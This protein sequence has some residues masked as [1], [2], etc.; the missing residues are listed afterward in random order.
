MVPLLNLRQNK[1][2]LAQHNDGENAS[3]RVENFSLI[4]KDTSTT[5]GTRN[6]LKKMINSMQPLN[7]IPPTLYTKTMLVQQTSVLHNYECRSLF[8]L[9]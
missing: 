3:L 4:A 6:R 8:A 5:I 9:P 7:K 2:R 1:E